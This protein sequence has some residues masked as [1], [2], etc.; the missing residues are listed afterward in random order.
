MKLNK[1]LK[2]LFFLILAGAMAISCSKNK[3]VNIPEPPKNEEPPTGSELAVTID[4]TSN[5]GAGPDLN[6][7]L[8]GTYSPQKWINAAKIYDKANVLDP[9]KVPFHKVNLPNVHNIAG[10]GTW[11]DIFDAGQPSQKSILNSLRSAGVGIHVGIESI[12]NALRGDAEKVQRLFTTSLAAVRTYV[13]ND[14]DIYYEILNEPELDSSVE[15]GYHP[16]FELFWSDFK[17]AYIALANKRLS[18]PKIKIG[19][20]GFELDRWLSVFM[21]KLNNPATGTVQLA[22]GSM[23]TIS[24]DFISYHN[25]LNWDDAPLAQLNTQPALDKMNIFFNGIVT[26]R[27]AHP[28]VKLF[29]TEYSWLKSP[30]NNVNDVANNGYRNCARTLELAKLANEQLLHTDRFYWAQAMGQS[31][32]FGDDYFTL[33]NFDWNTG[34]YKYRSGYYAFWIYQQLP[35]ARNTITYESDKLNGLASSANG[36][37]YAVVWNRTGENQTIKLNLT[38]INTANYNYNMYVINSTT[39]TYAKGNPKTP[40]LTKTGVANNI[41]GIVLEKEATVFLELTPK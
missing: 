20:P 1:T 41:A 3:S 37:Y 30:F 9:I 31:A 27:T 4:F 40:A 19:G 15:W 28:A 12:P 5:D 25:Y 18:D 34:M 36:K 26:Y 8:L 29:C 6:K 35:K 38:K 11:N 21:E 10:D 17:N 22:D 39:F 16:N 33:E 7:E 14:V 13:G 32:D 2:L 23:H 24:L